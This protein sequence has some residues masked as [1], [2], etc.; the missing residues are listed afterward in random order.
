MRLHRRKNARILAWP[1]M[2]RK[3]LA[4]CIC[5]KFAILKSCFSRAR[6]R[7]LLGHLTFKKYFLPN[8]RRAGRM[9]IAPVLKTGVRKGMGVRIP[10][11]PPLLLLQIKHLP[12]ILGLVFQQGYFS[13]YKTKFG[14]AIL[15]AFRCR[16]SQCLV[17][18]SPAKSD[19]QY[20]G[21]FACD[22]QELQGGITRHA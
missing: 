10:R 16:L 14:S 4:V 3:H 11:S 9:A 21:M 18:L 8:V 6:M 22:V 5:G 2:C 1:G 12:S 20:V 17:L 7:A 15:F 13:G 19:H